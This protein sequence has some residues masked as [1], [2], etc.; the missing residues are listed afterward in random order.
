MRQD[1][2]VQAA[3]RVDT[4]DDDDSAN[5]KAIKRQKDF[6]TSSWYRRAVLS[7]KPARARA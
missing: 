3:R 1:K 6:K 7:I 4:G 5:R 2:P